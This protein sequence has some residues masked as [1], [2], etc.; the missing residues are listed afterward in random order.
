MASSASSRGNFVASATQSRNVLRYSP[1]TLLTKASDPTPLQAQHE[2]VSSTNHALLASVNHGQP[3]IAATPRPGELNAHG[4]VGTRDATG[5]TH[6]PGTMHAP[7][8]SGAQ[9][10][11]NPATTAHPAAAPNGGVPPHQTNTAT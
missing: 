2:H 10:A 5:E 8:E 6:V 3:A 4:V 11:V 7:G 9:H 1:N